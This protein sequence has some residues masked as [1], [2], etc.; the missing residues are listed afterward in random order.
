MK[1]GILT[2]HR[3]YNYGA[4]LQCYSLSKKLA[5]DIPGACVEVIDYESENMFNYYRTDLLSLMFGHSSQA[6]KLTLRQRLSK[7]KMF[8]KKLKHN[9]SYIRKLKSRNTCFEE[10]VSHLAL[11]D[12]KLITDN[13]ST[14]I[15]FINEQNYDLI[16]VGSDAIWNDSQTSSPN[17][18]YLG[19]EIKA[20]YVS[21]AAS[22]FGMDYTLKSKDELN[23]IAESVKRFK[24]IGVRDKAT[25]DY[26]KLLNISTPML[27]TCDPSVFLD[28]TRSEFNIE[29][30]IHILEA[31]GIDFQKPVY[32]IMGGDWLGNIARQLIGPDAQL[33][34]L[35]EPN[36]YA[37]YYL[38]DLSPF[39][40]AKVF[41]LF[42]MT[43]THFF[44][45]TLFSL[46]NGTPT[47]SI[48]WEN[49][50]S[51]KFDTKIC[52]VLKRLNL[53][54][55][56]FTKKVAESDISVLK[57]HYSKVINDLE[58]EKERISRG[59]SNEQASYS[60]FLNDLKSLI[61]E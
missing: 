38:S 10:A 11:S 41:S 1:I 54:D 31:Q 6:F 47:M 55:Y 33:I 59:L 23:E 14:V 18:Y 2:F 37:D 15:D 56:R 60:N 3:A 48:E 61:Q 8:V 51:S 34:A 29:R 32:G 9:K 40:W 13:R 21:Y 20:D 49:S 35:Y 4:F 42:T 30:I 17:I 46:K 12:K 43:F 44:H 25:E 5:E 16:I 27:H 36:K 50:Y 52:D 26:I 22:S 57:N 19:K 28:L 58:K 7:A 24:L 45:G 39:E 53:E